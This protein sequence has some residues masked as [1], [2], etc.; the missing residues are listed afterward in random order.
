MDDLFLRDP[1][2]E[3]SATKL[4]KNKYCKNCPKRKVAVLNFKKK[5]LMLLFKTQI[6]IF[7]PIC[8][9][10]AIINDKFKNLMN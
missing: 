5:T 10:A 6:I 3:N 7:L 2:Y 4:C 8:A 9:H 1:Q